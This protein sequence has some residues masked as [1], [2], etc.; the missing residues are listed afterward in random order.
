VELIF[1][2]I[3]ARI[4]SLINNKNITNI[5]GSK[6]SLA[7]SYN[8]KKF[9]VLPYIN[10]I[11]ELISSTIDKTKY[12]TGFRVL[13]SLGRF[14]KVHK[15]TN[16]LHSN[17]NVVYKISCKDC[18]ASYVGQT[19]RQLKTRIKEHC[20]N[21]K[22][23]SSNPSVITEHM[24]NY[25]HAFDWNNVKILDTEANYFKRLVSEILHIKE[26]NG[27]NAQKNTELLDNSYFEVLDMLF[28][29]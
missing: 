13:N 29:F 24:L 8:N 9:V 15:D 1:E 5:R 3:N 11:S 17:N 19:K 26:S 4:K 27:L 16:N 2:K 25:S 18:D 23:L 10:G 7:H 12:I 6:E 20:N 28:K 14:I 22:L 21:Y